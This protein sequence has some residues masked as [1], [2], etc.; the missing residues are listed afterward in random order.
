MNDS[1][2]TKSKTLKFVTVAFILICTAF[3]YSWG[4]TDKPISLTDFGIA[5]TAI[6]TPWIGREWVKK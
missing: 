3:V 2:G 5:F 1:V 4:W 6:L